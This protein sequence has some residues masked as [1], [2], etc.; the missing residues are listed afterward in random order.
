MTGIS[1]KMNKANEDFAY[2][3]SAVERFKIALLQLARKLPKREARK[4]R[5]PDPKAEGCT[6]DGKQ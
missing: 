4:K 2:A 3:T 1:E 5:A 6:R